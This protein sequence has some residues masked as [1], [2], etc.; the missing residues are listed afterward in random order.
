M[1]PVFRQFPTWDVT[2]YRT[3]CHL[4]RAQPGSL[5]T[6][7]GENLHKH[8]AQLWDSQQVWERDIP[9]AEVIALKAYLAGVVMKG[10]S[11]KKF[12][13]QFLSDIPSSIGF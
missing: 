11:T 1:F 2:Y 4:P 7:A 6:P 13:E 12:W 8:T 10:P 5:C 3:A 9:A